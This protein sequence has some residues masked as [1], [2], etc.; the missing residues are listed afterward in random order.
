MVCDTGVQNGDGVLYEDQSP[1]TLPLASRG[2]VGS[3]SESGHMQEPPK[4]TWDDGSKND[5]TV[6]MIDSE[7]GRSCDN[8]LKNDDIRKQD[9]GVAM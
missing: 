8:K 4:W 1:E 2:T 7:S 3:E 6:I 9:H 5:Q